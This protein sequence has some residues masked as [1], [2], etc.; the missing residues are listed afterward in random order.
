MLVD[1]SHGNRLKSNSVSF[2]LRQPGKIENCRPVLFFPPT[3]LRLHLAFIP[4]MVPFGDVL[5]YFIG[6][7]I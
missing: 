4:L 7:R 6:M 1:L 5:P 3:D 2:V